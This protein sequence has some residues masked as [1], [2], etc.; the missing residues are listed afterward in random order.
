M[1]LFLLI[2]VIRIFSAPSLYKFDFALHETL[3]NREMHI[4]IISSFLLLLTRDDEALN[5]LFVEVEGII[6]KSP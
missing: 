3:A 6:N 4:V 2:S 5:T 1:P